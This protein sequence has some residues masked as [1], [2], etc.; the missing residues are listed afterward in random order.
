MALYSHERQRLAKCS[1]WEHE[2]NA[3]K[4]RAKIFSF[5]GIIRKNSLQTGR[6]RLRNHKAAS[7]AAVLYF[8]M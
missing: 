7:Q 4:G 2:N 8:M 6:K 1:F 3:A 5:F